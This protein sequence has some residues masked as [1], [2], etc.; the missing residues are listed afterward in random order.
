MG[1]A[2]LFIDVERKSSQKRKK[3]EIHCTTS[4]MTFKGI[5]VNAPQIIPF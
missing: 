4:G 1:F 5:F 2:N 3:T